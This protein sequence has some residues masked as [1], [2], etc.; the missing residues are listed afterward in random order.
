MRLSILLVALA[1]T[2]CKDDPLYCDENTPCADPARPFCDLNGEYPASEGIKRTC[3]PDPFGPD[4]G[5]DETDGGAERS[6]IQLATT[7]NTSCAVLSDGGL[8]CWGDAMLGGER[9]G[10]DEHPREAGDIETDGPIAEVAIGG[11]HI[12]VRYRD[13]AV[14]CWGENGEGELGYGHSDPIAAPPGQLTDVAIGGS[15]TKICA[16]GSFTC[17]VLEGGTVRCWGMNLGGQLGY[18]HTENIG[19]DEL[20]T[21]EP[22]PID[23]GGL[24]RELSCASGYSCAVLEGGGLR[25]WGVNTYGRLGYGTSGNVGDNETPAEA[26]FVNV[27]GGVESVAVGDQNACVVLTEGTV[28]CWGNRVGLGV[29][30]T[31]EPIGDDEDPVAIDPVDVGGD[32]RDITTGQAFACA[33]LETDNVTCWGGSSFG[34]LGY[35]SEEQVGDDETPAEAG[36]VMLGGAVANVSTGGGSSRIH[37]CALLTSGDVRCWGYNDNGQLGLGSMID[38]VGDNETPDSQDPVQIL[39]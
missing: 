34:Q 8:R 14:R 27:G 25:C 20:P 30:G 32:V 16:G 22:N 37:S 15:A 7:G 19:D 12:C 31:S 17:A 26:G 10:D 18:G 21:D 5:P 11:D 13:G 1:L 35:G 39:D 24:V 33:V 28:R 23:M 2:S 6:V 9:I 3:I 38:A 29:P 36:A 4:S